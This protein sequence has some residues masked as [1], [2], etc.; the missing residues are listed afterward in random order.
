MIQTLLVTTD[1]RVFAELAAGLTEKGT[2]VA[3]A[4]SCGAAL[5]A[6]ASNGYHLAVIDEQLDGTTG[7][8][9]IKQMMAV[10][11]MIN[12]AVVSTLSAEAFH[13]A[14]EGLG[15]LMPLAREPD[16]AAT[17]ALWTHLERIL[18]LNPGVFP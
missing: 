15:V 10:N 16:K 6:I 5:T 13:E 1:P 9:C 18:N 2:G 11:P 14:S 3:W 7:L 8:A 12:C 17:H 4:D